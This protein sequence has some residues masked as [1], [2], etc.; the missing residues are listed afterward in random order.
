[1]H[2]WWS[3][4]NINQSIGEEKI[5]RWWRYLIDRLGAYNVIWIGAGEYNLGNYGGFTLDFWKS[6]GVMIKKEDPY[7]RIVSYHPTPP[8]WDGGDKAP[9]WSTS[10]VMHTEP[11]LDYNQS[12]PGHGKWRNEMIPGIVRDAYNRKPSKPIVVTE[13]WYEF[14]EGNADAKDIRFGAWSAFLSGAAGHTYGGGHIWLA[15]TPESP[16]G[17]GPWPLEKSFE[18]N[19]LN[20]PGA[21]SMGTMSTILGQLPWWQ[22]EPDP[23]LIKEYAEPYCAAIPGQHYLIYLRYGGGCKIDL[24]DQASEEF[25]YS[26]IDPFT[27]KSV[28][29][30]KVKGGQIIF[31]SP[32]GDYPGVLNYRDW[33]IH[34]KRI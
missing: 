34:I 4:E 28:R 33:L 25:Q 16:A 23:G 14:A 24:K 1:V 3:R 11:W 19:T 21:I 29:S 15:H 8:G 10:E 2:A 13:P 17:G 12:Q 26:W 18:K 6:L 30:G 5:L 20:Y 31:L 22:L 9:Q 7:K 32:P 27:G